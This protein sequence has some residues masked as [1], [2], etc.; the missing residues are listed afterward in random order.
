MQN[1]IRKLTTTRSIIIL[2]LVTL[3]F[4]L[5]FAWYSSGIA[6]SIPDTQI[7]YTAEGLYEIFTSLGEAGRSAYLTVTLLLD[8]L[9]PVAYTLLLV[10]LIYRLSAGKKQ[11]SLL[12]L[13]IFILDYL[14][15][16]TIILLLLHYPGELPWLATMAGFFTLFK[17]IMVIVCVAIVVLLA[18]RKL[19]NKKKQGS[20]G[21]YQQNGT[22]KRK[23]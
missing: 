16:T 8:Y 18:I 20:G 11:L 10:A 2:I 17:W 22:V 13:A 12:P 3:M 7:F 4:N 23:G 6:T 9:Y 21:F 15:N 1:F 19:I 14:E 5:A